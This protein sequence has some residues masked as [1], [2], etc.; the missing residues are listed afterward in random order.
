M[1]KIL[2]RHNY[3]ITARQSPFNIARHVPG[4]LKIRTSVR[5]CVSVCVR[6]RACVCVRTCAYKFKAACM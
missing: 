5:V 6:A 4:F 3:C 2:Q 1:E